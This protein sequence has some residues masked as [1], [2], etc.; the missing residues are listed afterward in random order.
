VGLS[1]C[2]GA[3]AGHRHHSTDLVQV[4]RL[5]LKADSDRAAISP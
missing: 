3:D 5:D 1:L 4:E 2:A